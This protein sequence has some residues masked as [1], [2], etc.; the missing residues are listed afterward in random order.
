VEW[1][2][3]VLMPIWNRISMLMTTHIRIRI[4]IGIKAMPVPAPN[5]THVEKPEYF[6][7]FYSQHCQ[8]AMFIYL[9]S[10]KCTIILS[11]F[12]TILT[13]SGKSYVYQ[14]FNLLGLDTDP[15]LHA[16]D[17]DPDKPK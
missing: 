8:I 11:I 3:I 2:G 6:F 4:R 9:I 12:D 7:Y 15:D 16:L 10:V 17:A 5:F 1:I 13:S 14:L